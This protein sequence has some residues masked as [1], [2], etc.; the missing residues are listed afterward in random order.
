MNRQIPRFPWNY[1]IC[2]LLVF[3]MWVSGHICKFRSRKSVGLFPGDVDIDCN[4]I[5]VYHDLYLGGRF[6]N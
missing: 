5:N 1:S 3:W 4:R 2:A 6:S